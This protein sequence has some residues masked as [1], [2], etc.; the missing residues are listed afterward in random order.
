MNDCPC[1]RLVARK[2]GVDDPV[3]EAV[4][5]KPR[6][7]HQVDVLGV[8][9][10]LKVPHQP[11]EGVSCHLIVKRVERIRIHRNHSLSW[12]AAVP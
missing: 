4:A 6:Q 5:A 9:P 2:T 1:R 11:A 7:T 3:G 12:A 10:V 8:M